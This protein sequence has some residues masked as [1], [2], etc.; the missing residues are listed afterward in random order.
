M[1]KHPSSKNVIKTETSSK[2]QFL[3][4]RSS[5]TFK[6]SVENYAKEHNTSTAALITSCLDAYMNC[7]PDSTISRQIQYSMEVK[8]N[9]MKN[10]IM[11]MINL[12]QT[13]PEKAKERIRRELNYIV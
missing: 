9:I 10:K 1:N 7:P 8:N 3:K 2:N 5:Q 12:D 4:A 13:I 11:N 6:T